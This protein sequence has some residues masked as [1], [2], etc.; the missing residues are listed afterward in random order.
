MSW[1]SYILKVYFRIL[2]KKWNIFKI[3]TSW[4][5]K[6]SRIFSAIPIANEQWQFTYVILKFFMHAKTWYSWFGGGI[7]HYF[8]NLTFM[9]CQKK[10]RNV[11]FYFQI[12][13]EKKGFD[14]SSFS[15]GFFAF[16]LFRKLYFKLHWSL[17][18]HRMSQDFFLLQD[19]FMGIIPSYIEL[20]TTNFFCA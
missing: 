20:L 14:T 10:Y 19:F 11:L 8:Q 18:D 17:T 9:S 12:R 3:R 13:I 6:F 5:H 1:E 4:N 16:C 7:T 2:L 15:V